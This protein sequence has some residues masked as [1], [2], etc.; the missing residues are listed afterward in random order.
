MPDTFLLVGVLVGI[1][2]TGDLSIGG[3]QFEFTSSLFA[4]VFVLRQDESTLAFTFV[5]SNGVPTN[6][7]AFTIVQIAFIHV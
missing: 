6:L 4:V 1:I 3:V 2:G 5:R 7:V